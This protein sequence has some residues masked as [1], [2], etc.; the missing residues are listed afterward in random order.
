MT[1]NHCINKTPTLSH[2]QPKKCSGFSSRTTRHPHPLTRAHTPTLT[3]SLWTCFLLCIFICLLV[4]RATSKK[5]T[6]WLEEGPQCLI[7]STSR[8]NQ[9]KMEW[10][11]VYLF[12]VLLSGC[13]WFIHILCKAIEKRRKIAASISWSPKH[14]NLIIAHQ[15]RTHKYYIYIGLSLD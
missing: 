1:K 15:Y 6:N 10:K 11:I 3:L 9:T 5:K 12:D 8:L 2:G 4:C 14:S 7:Y 13:K